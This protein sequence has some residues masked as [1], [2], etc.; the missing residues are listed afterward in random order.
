MS[1]SN[2]DS[3]V[4]HIVPVTLN[5]YDM[6]YQERNSFSEA[7]LYCHNSC[8]HFPQCFPTP[9][10]F[11]HLGILINTFWSNCCISEYFLKKKSV[12]YRHNHLNCEIIMSNFSCQA[13]STLFNKNSGVILLLKYISIKL[14]S[15]TFSKPQKNMLGFN[16]WLI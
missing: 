11:Q 3:T 2:K 7:F 10:D 1:R 4:F 6:N 13:M 5:H 16:F 8:H 15:R 14:Q 9:I 12:I